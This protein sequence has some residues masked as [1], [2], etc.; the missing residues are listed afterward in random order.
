LKPRRTALITGLTALTVGAITATT[1]F[2]STTTASH[3]TQR[4][5]RGP[6]AVRVLSPRPGDNTGV[7]GA[8]WIVDLK[9]NFRSV[10][11]SG[12]TAP[13][14]TGPGAHANAAPFPGAFGTG[15]DEALPG[16]VVLSSTTTSSIPGFS[17]PG[18]NLAG[19]F[20]ITSVTDRSARG[21]QIQDT[22]IVGAP[23]AGQNVPSVLTVAVVGDLNHDGV[24]NDAPSAVSDLNHDGRIDAGDLRALGVAGP[25]RTVRFRINGS[26]L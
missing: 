22:W 21:A 7:A 1:A 19:L 17:G 15:R 11:A 5:D 18:T 16:L 20:N 26:A 24:Y 25:I 6:V 10:A 9:L 3:P 23:I 12:F 14:L 13:Q 8:G 4:T 2:A